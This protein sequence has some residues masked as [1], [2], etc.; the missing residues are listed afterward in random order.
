MQ[1]AAGG[2]GRG[3]NGMPTPAQI[4]AMQVSAM[5]T[6]PRGVS[7]P[8][9]AIDAPWDVT[10]NAETDAQRWGHAGDD[11]GHDAGAGRRPVRYGG[12]AT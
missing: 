4:Q 8:E 1:A 10:T 9:A 5:G 7:D 2:K 11:E 12:D 6:F 3:A